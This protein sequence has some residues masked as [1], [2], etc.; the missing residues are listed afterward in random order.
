MPGVQTSDVDAAIRQLVDN[1][2]VI[3]YVVINGDGIPVKYHEKMPY[4]QVLCY[5][6]S[7]PV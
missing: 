1:D 2:T 4:A 5:C 6:Y 7:S 3:G